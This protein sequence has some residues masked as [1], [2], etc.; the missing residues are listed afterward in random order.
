[1]YN[2]HIYYIY[3]WHVAIKVVSIDTLV[4]TLSFIFGCICRTTKSLVLWLCVCNNIQI[5]II[6]HMCWISTGWLL[7]D[8]VQ[9]DVTWLM[10]LQWINKV[11][12]SEKWLSETMKKRA[13]TPSPFSG[14]K[15][16]K[17]KKSYRRISVILIEI[18]W[19]VEVTELTDKNGGDENGC[20]MQ[21]PVINY[22]V[23]D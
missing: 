3:R 9:V 1:M 5:S 8:H 20:D 14:T 15:N 19:E 22:Q 17:L 23:I 18:L 16:V 11:L 13:L 2:A 6:I 21:N 7:W 12:L 4:A 10:Q